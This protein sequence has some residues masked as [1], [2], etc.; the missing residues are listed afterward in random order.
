LLVFK[1]QLA[2]EDWSQVLLSDDINTNFNDFMGVLNYHYQ[3]SFPVKKIVIKDSAKQNNYTKNWYAKELKTEKAKLDN[4][5]FQAKTFK[6]DCAKR[7]HNQAKNV[8]RKNI[9]HAK[10][11]ANQKKVQQSDNKTKAL[12]EIVNKIKK[13]IRNT[14]HSSTKVTPNE[15][16]NVF[17]NVGGVMKNNPMVKNKQFEKLL[18][19]H[20]HT[21]KEQFSFKPVNEDDVL[22]VVHFF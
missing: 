15:F 3:L 13:C 20:K 16:N 18:K 10:K 8:Y 22:K 4:L 12:W 7:K 14:K 6:T 5:Y 21:V 11:Q 1:S 19:N 2:K 9:N 17:T